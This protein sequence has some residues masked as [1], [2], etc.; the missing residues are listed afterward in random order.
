MVN[1]VMLVGNLGRDPEMRALPSGQQVA[2]FSLA[3]SRRYK[4][5]DGNRKDETEWHNIVVFGKQAEIAGQYLTKGKMVFVEGRIQTRSWDDK[6][7]GKKQY[8]TEII[9]ENFQM[10]GAK[11][12]SGGGR[13]FGAGAPSG[14][15]SDPGHDLPDDDIPF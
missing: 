8:K 10:L 15:G 1:K 11:G 9:C 7:S 4:D 13:D 14:G 2:N 6:E 3:T 5:R 12:D